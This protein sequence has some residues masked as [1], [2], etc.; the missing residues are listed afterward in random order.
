MS[1]ADIGDWAALMSLASTF[2]TAY[3]S[4]STRAN[5]PT[6]EEIF[7]KRDVGHRLA[8]NVAGVSVNC[9]FFIIDEIELD[10]DPKEVRS[11]E[12]HTALLR[13]VRNLAVATGRDV[14][15]THEGAPS[16]HILSFRPN[17]NRWEVDV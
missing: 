16:E 17:E 9:H 10:V 5:L 7:A 2:P 11:D 15:L 8:I 12:Q 4:D 3:F 1:P 13:F 14:V 6:I